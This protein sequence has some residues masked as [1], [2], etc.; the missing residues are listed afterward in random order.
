MDEMNHKDNRDKAF[1]H[2][3][4]TDKW[5]GDESVLGRY[6][7]SINVI[8]NPEAFHKN[9]FVLILLFCWFVMLVLF[10]YH[11]L[12]I[13]FVIFESIYKMIMGSDDK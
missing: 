5:F 7:Y 9:P 3:P 13:I 10:F 2:F 12:V 4:I 11:P 1:A 8:K 6:L